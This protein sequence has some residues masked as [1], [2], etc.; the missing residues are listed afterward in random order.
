MSMHWPENS[1]APTVTSFSVAPMSG[2]AQDVYYRILRLLKIQA[3]NHLTPSAL[4]PLK[5]L[6]MYPN[7]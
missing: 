3:P 7:F 4:H 6:E 1:S 2:C 5:S